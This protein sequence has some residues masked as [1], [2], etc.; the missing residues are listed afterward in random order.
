MGRWDISILARG[1]CWYNLPPMPAS[2][3]EI[4][5]LL[6]ELSRGNQE[7]RESLIELVYPELKRIAAYY[8]RME[9][10][11]HTLQPT[12]IVHEAFLRLIEQQNVDWK[13]RAHFFAVA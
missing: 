3:G 9:R 10:P 12:A 11:G 5:V 6:K 2:P 13:D 1:I 4:T 7:V 8:M